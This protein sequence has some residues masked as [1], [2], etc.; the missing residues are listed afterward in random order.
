MVAG[1]YPRCR[2]GDGCHSTV[3]FLEGFL[4]VHRGTGGFDP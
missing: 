3:V 4:G 1:Q 2:F